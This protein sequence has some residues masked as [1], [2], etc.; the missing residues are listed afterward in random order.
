MCFGIDTLLTESTF[1]GR[2]SV[3]MCYGGQKFECIYVANKQ[4]KMLFKICNKENNITFSTLK[5]I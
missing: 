1:C 2:N 5:R 3:L 4:N